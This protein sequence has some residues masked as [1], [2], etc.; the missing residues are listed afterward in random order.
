MDFPTTKELDQMLEKKAQMEAEEDKLRE[1]ARFKMHDVAC[2]QILE[3]A[4]KCIRERF[5][6]SKWSLRVIVDAP[7]NL[8][9]ELVDRD[10]IQSNVQD[11]IKETGMDFQIF[12]LLD[13]P[14]WSISCGFSRIDRKGSKPRPTR[15]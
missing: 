6:N 12:E 9:T 5:D 14:R 11:K 1:E 13:G 15:G 2:E 7:Y 8:K 4:A 3:E 10:I